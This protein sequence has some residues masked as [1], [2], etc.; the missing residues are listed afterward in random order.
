MKLKG[1]VVLMIKEGPNAKF[2]QEQES[3]I[4]ISHYK[5]NSNVQHC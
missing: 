1:E 3:S 2:N 5:G 4:L